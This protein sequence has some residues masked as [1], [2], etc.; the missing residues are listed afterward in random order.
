[1]HVIVLI[2]LFFSFGRRVATE[3]I[4]SGIFYSNT[5]DVINIPSYDVI[6]ITASSALQCAVEC[7][8][9]TRCNAVVVHKRTVQLCSLLIFNSNVNV[10]YTVNSFLRNK[11]TVWVR[12][13]VVQRNPATAGKQVMPQTSEAATTTTASETTSVVSEFSSTTKLEGKLF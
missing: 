11:T 1:M 6:N 3:D 9:N 4:R 12:Q 2:T 10:N 7:L 8:A 13:S 5:V